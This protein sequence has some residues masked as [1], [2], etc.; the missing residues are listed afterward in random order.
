LEALE[1]KVGRHDKEIFTILEVIRQL[2]EP[3]EKPKGR[4][5]FHP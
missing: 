1:Q 2:M 5:G 3:P 4:I